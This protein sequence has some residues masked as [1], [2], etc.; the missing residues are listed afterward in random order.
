M[1][2]NVKEDV[3]TL[4]AHAFDLLRRRAK[5]LQ[6]VSALDKML[7]DIDRKIEELEAKLK[8]EKE[9]DNQ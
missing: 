1:A 4:K 3:V 2:T 9:D 5:L 8:E 7:A 6:E